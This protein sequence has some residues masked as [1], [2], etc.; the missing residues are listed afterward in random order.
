MEEFNRISKELPKAVQYASLLKQI[1]SLVSGEDNK[2]ANLANISA[3]LKTQFDYWW[4]GF[5]LMDAESLVLGPFQGP[6]ACTRIPVGK[7]VCGK[8]AEEKR[9]ILVP[10]VN[11]FPGHIACSAESKSEL[12][13]PIVKG[14]NTLAVL[15]IDSQYLNYFDEQDQAF[16]EEL[17]NFIAEWM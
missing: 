2:I 6:L 13:I 17:T 8:A 11:A 14:T 5:Y 9:S 16:Y 1:K 4:V 7:G 3:V 15:D 10:D 12:V